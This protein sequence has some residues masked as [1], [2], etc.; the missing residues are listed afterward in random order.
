MKIGIF[1]AGAYGSAMAGVLRENGHRVKFF[2]PYK[3]PDSDI[4]EVAEYAQVILLA[5][6]A[7]VSSA[8]IKQIPAEALLKPAIIT[9]KGVM[10]VGLWENFQYFELVAGPGF[11]DDIRKKKKTYLTVAGRGAMQGRTL[12]EEL[13]TT[14]YLKLDKTD[15]VSGVA[16]LSGLKNIYAIE[17][18]RRGLI[19]GTV[20]F[21]EY[22]ADVAKEC[23]KFLLYNGGFVETVRLNAGLGDLVLTAGS[24]DSR[25]YTFGTLIG[26]R[27]KVVEKK[28]LAKRYLDENTVEGIFAAREIGRQNLAI[29]K[30]NEIL[31][32]A[33]RRL[34]NVVKC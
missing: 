15:D 22:I 2:D 1:G 13:L 30:E 28:R 29:P 8:L 32:D 3:I 14:S 20:E 5:T 26:G 27:R 23:E 18:G 4:E 25:N 19:F 24:P 9:T 12:S 11:A 31:I 6:P 7:E 34:R 21:K 33:I 10:N 16:F 17:A